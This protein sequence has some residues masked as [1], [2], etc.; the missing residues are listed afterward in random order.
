M[1]RNIN[2]DAN[3][4]RAKSFDDEN[5]ELKHVGAG[6]LSMANAGELMILILHVYGTCSTLMHV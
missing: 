4:E 6:I 2:P 1:E 5:F 3:T